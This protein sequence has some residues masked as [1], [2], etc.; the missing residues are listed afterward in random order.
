MFY[1]EK[2]KAKDEDKRKRAKENLKFYPVVE[3]R[4]FYKNGDITKEE[5]NNLVIPELQI[6]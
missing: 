1:N 2:V 3:L 4:R 6:K 5:F